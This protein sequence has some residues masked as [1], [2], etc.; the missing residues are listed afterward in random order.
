L[1]RAVTLFHK[2]FDQV[3]SQVMALSV[4]YLMLVFPVETTCEGL[5][6]GRQLGLFMKHW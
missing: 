1:L 4:P 6:F 3:I 2:G 5:L